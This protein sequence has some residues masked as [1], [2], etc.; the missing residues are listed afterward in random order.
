MSVE[1]GTQDYDDMGLIPVPPFIDKPCKPIRSGPPLSY[2]PY[3]SCWNILEN[4]NRNE[5]CLKSGSL[6]QIINLANKTSR[7]RSSIRCR[8]QQ[9]SNKFAELV[10]IKN[11]QSSLSTS[12]MINHE[13]GRTNQDVSGFENIFQ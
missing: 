10:C 1:N 7:V 9:L 3:H 8:S 12:S 6:L 4:S 5:T 13:F 11:Q 2:H